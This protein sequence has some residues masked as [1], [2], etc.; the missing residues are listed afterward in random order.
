MKKRRNVLTLVT[1]VII[2]LIFVLYMIT[3]VV[4]EGEVA[5][6]TTF[7]KVVRVIEQKPGLYW[8]APP[9]IQRVVTFDARLHTDKDRFEETKTSDGVLL[10]LLAYYTWRVEDPKLFYT[11]FYT[12][13]EAET[14]K[15]ARKVLGDVVRDAKDDVFGEYAFADLMPRFRY[16]EK[17]AS[18]TDVEKGSRA[19]E[20][21]AEPKFREI[22]AEI[23]K[24][25]KDKAL[26]E[27]GVAVTQ[28]GIMRFELPQ[29]T[30]RF[31]F[32]R[33]QEERERVA[34][35][36]RETGRGEADKIR[37]RADTARDQIVAAARAQAEQERALGDKEAAE[38]YD[39]FAKN[40]ELHDFLRKLQA[41]GTII[42]DGT[43]LILSTDSV[44]FELLREMPK[45]LLGSG[46]ESGADD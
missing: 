29:E 4:R 22:E 18:E 27:Y 46:D 15:A 43:T 38:Y 37:T 14:L 32:K 3:Y 33:M 24:R 19:R 9:P 45:A 8:K 40:P 28:V 30:T 5:V 10:V 39:T 31:V 26:E 23:L 21:E 17:A 2:V 20:V 11:K 25:V 35:G 13:D 41:L 1:A 36:I 42:D 16:E 12:R 34:A 7:Q 6:L 44:P